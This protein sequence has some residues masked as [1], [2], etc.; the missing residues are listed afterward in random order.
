M[1]AQLTVTAQVLTNTVGDDV[2]PVGV[3][4]K[5]NS[6]HFRDDIARYLA[7]K[8]LHVWQA[9]QGITDYV[10]GDMV[11]HEEYEETNLIFSVLTD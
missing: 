5:A 3:L 8:A 9:E 11:F 1:P 10:M 2:T 4:V 6:E 7:A